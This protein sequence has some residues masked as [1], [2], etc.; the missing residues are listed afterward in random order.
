MTVKSSED[1]VRKETPILHVLL[2]KEVN[3]TEN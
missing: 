2:M 3:A 1:I